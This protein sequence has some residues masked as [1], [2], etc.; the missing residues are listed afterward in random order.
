MLSLARKSGRIL[1]RLAII[2]VSLELLLQVNTIL[3]GGSIRIDEDPKIGW[4]LRPHQHRAYTDD[5]DAVLFETNSL[6]YRDDEPKLR[7]PRG[8]RRIVG[9]GNSTALG[10]GVEETETFYA[11]VEE[12]LR[13][14]EVLNMA[15]V[16]LSA[17]QCFRVLIDEGLRFEPDVV[18]Q[19]VVDTD[20]F[21]PFASWLPILGPKCRLELLENRLKFHAPNRS[22]W[23][24]LL[25]YSS[26]LEHGANTLIGIMPSKLA[27]YRSIDGEYRA[28]ALAILLLT[29]RHTCA[30]RGIDYV[31]V[32][33]PDIIMVD[34]EKVPRE[35]YVPLTGVVLR[36]LIADENLPVLDTLEVMRTAMRDPAQPSPFGGNGHHLN[37]AGQRLLATEL[38]KFLRQRPAYRTT[39]SAGLGGR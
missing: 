33:L 22:L 4:R 23:T 32:Y 17:D 5:A 15:S 7:R 26:L 14:T 38:A 20:I 9:L 1:F 13:R 11:L 21:L 29:A 24:E 12:S 27:P 31:V 28:K 18:V 19:L 36:R 10:F 30:Q 2:L 39:E 16:G 25:S 3:R 34:P 8:S 35:D 37:Q 6:G